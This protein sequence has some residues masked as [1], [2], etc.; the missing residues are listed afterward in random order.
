MFKAAMKWSNAVSHESFMK[1]CESEVKA[2][3]FG[4]CG[5]NHQLL[6][7]QGVPDQ[8]SLEDRLLCVETSEASVK[9]AKAVIEVVASIATFVS[10]LPLGNRVPEHKHLQQFGISWLRE[11][12]SWFILCSFLHVSLF[13][14]PTSDMC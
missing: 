1:T 6:A 5:F 2:A 10:F 11:P 14:H 13:C 12:L 4:S 3:A 9:V 7:L 8:E